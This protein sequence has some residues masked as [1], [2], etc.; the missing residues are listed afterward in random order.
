ML[1]VGS[2]IQRQSMTRTCELHPLGGDNL[3]APG[4]HISLR[5]QH[6]R[7]ALGGRDCCDALA[8]SST[9]PD[10]LAHMPQDMIFLPPK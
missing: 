3:V 4:V 2:H 9:I 1:K 6:H 10:V 8:L 7:V 5:C